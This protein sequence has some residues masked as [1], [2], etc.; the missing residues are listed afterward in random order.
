MGELSAD[1]PVKTQRRSRALTRNDV[2]SVI[3]A[4]KDQIRACYLARLPDAPDLGG[5]LVV[6][7][8]IV[9]GVVATAEI[10]DSST[11]RDG[12]LEACVL[13]RIRG[14]A[15]AAADGKVRYPFLFDPP[16]PSS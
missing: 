5:K 16:R 7:F 14:L 11:L 6:D 15:F 10:A 12:P 9:Q 2:D 8:Q 1:G 4:A 13:D 3:K